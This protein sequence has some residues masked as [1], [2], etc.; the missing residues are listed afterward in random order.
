MQTVLNVDPDEVRAAA[1][2]WQM[3]GAD[4]GTGGAPSVSLATTWPSAVWARGLR[5]AVTYARLVPLTCNNFGGRGRY[6]T[7]DRWCVK[8]ELYH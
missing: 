5:S 2:R 4:L 6:R 8:P 1:S 3:I 7:A